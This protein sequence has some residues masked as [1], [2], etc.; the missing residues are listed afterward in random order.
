MKNKTIRRFVFGIIMAVTF[1]FT[2]L[3]SW[4]LT[5]KTLKESI[6]KW[7]EELIEEDLK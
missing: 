5:E 6:I 1:P 4:L 3:S 2:V 7:C